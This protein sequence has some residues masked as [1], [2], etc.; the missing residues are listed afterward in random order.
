MLN[1]KPFN[2]TIGWDV[3]GAHL[4]AALLDA[5]GALLQVL[6]VSCALWRGLPE[7]EAAVDQ[8]LSH[9]KV[10]TALHGITMT[11]ELVDLFA[12]REEGVNAIST[13]MD[14]KLNGVKQFYVGAT[15]SADFSGFLS[16]AEVP[17]SWQSIAS[18]NWMA[19][20]CFSA[21]Q[22][23][24]LRNKNHAVLIDIG[25]TTTDFIPLINGQLSCLGFSDASRMQFEE[26]VYTGVIRTPLMAIAQK[27]NFDLGVTS[28]AA[29]FFA[30]SGD[31]YRLTGDLL[32][33][34]DMAD[35]ADGKDKS[36][37]ASARRIARMVGH[38]VDDADMMTWQSLAKAFK[39]KQCERLMEV[40]KAHIDRIAIAGHGD[41]VCIIGA[42]VGHF[43]VK[44]IAEKMQRTY[45][46]V[47]ELFNSNIAD[48]QQH[49]AS[50]CLPAYA[51]ACLIYQ[52]EIAE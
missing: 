35:T 48:T 26:L 25:S 7:L 2:H 42:G 10:K 13:L 37:F 6:Q 36:L 49:Q 39:A 46:D 32:V 12:N 29:E 51:V 30:T 3:G 20:A 8:V 27:I 21:R 33:S 14:A 24:T 40:T 19:S 22:L 11:G 15:T 5:D 16:L 28:V 47:S 50:V 34:E 18:A 9:F 1:P 45:M 52:C 31:V 4:K 23:K 17:Q 41:D 44:Q 38:D 43:L